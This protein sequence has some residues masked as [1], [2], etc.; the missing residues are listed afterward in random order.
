MA[1]GNPMR[2][3]FIFA[4]LANAALV[5]ISYLV[6]PDRVATHFN[7]YGAADAWGPKESLVITLLPV[8][9]LVLLMALVTPPL[10]FKLPPGMINLP[11][12]DY[13]LSEKN[14]PQTTRI[15]SNLMAEFGVAL[16]AFLFLVELFVLDAN[17]KE[18]AG[19][20]GRIFLAVLIAF[21][22]YAI[23]WCIKLFRSFRI[24]SHA[25]TR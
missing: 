4:F 21:I 23:Y 24:P 1:A 15:F 10:V 17:F 6:L 20:D 22:L 8:H 11:N 14:K 7:F 3:L 13:W 12:K 16:L 25:S 18:P 5:V 19:M 9:L 2:K